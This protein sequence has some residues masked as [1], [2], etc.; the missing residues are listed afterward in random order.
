MKKV[1]KRI[2]TGVICAAMVLT[3]SISLA[4]AATTIDVEY[5]MENN[6]RFFDE[7]FVKYPLASISLSNFSYDDAYLARVKEITMDIVGNETN[8]VKQLELVKAW[9]IKY[10]G[11]SGDAMDKV[12]GEEFSKYTSRWMCVERS[13]LFTE[14]CR[15]LNIETVRVEGWSWHNDI[16]K[17]PNSDGDSHRWNLV[18]VNDEWSV[19]DASWFAASGPFFFGNIEESF[20]YREYRRIVLTNQYVSDYTCS[21]YAVDGIKEAYMNYL[22]PMSIS[23]YLKNYSFTTDA[24]RQAFC[25]YVVQLYSKTTGIAVVDLRSQYESNFTDFSDC[26]NYKVGI[27]SALGIVNGVGDNKFNPKG[28]ITRQEAATM[29]MRLGKLLGVEATDEVV[30]FNDVSDNSWAKEGIDYVS[31]LGIM[32]GVGNDN[33]DPNGL[34]THEQT[35]LTMVRL[36]DMV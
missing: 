14:M 2:V 34:Y 17:N 32:N 27:A 28:N 8:P 36:F 13:N 9:F 16:T 24:N 6:K 7:I 12:I 25:A 11:Y 15:I 20:K 10:A 5:V 35:I 23:T 30:K 4:Y 29:L 19:C 18:Y 33:F 21:D 22:L 3:S 31:S 1:L 26:S